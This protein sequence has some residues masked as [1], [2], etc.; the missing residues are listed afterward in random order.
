MMNV[1]ESDEG[2]NLYE[3][4]EQLCFQHIK[5]NFELLMK[6]LT[7]RRAHM[8]AV[9]F[10]LSTYLTSSLVISPWCTNICKSVNP[11]LNIGFVYVGTR[12]CFTNVHELIP[13]SLT[14][15]FN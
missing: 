7:E 8:C 12:I 3:Y 13:G 14:I 4:T 11:I 1:C 10:Q 9:L 15:G 2:L 5:T 6:F